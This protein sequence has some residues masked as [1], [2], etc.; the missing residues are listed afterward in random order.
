MPNFF[1][2]RGEGG[3]CAINL[4]QIRLVL[5]DNDIRTATVYFEPDHTMVFRDDTAEQFLDAL[6][7]SRPK[8]RRV[9]VK[10]TA[11]E[12]RKPSSSS[13]QSLAWN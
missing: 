13:G 11:E 7:R 10:G 4:D 2:T 8:A 6:K 3:S 1:F 5:W 12:E 9:R